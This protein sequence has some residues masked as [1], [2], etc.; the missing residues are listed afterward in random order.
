MWRGRIAATA[1]VAAI[2]AACT[3][4]GYDIS[5]LAPQAS[6]RTSA[7]VGGPRYAD[8]DPH[9]WAGRTPWT[10]AIHGTDVAKYQN[11]V[12]WR[13]LRRNGISFAFIK[14]T[15]GGDLVDER[16]AQNWRGAKAAGIPRGAYHFYYFCR[17][18]QEQAAWFIRNVPR[19]AAAL[20]PVLDMEWNPASPTCRLRPPPATVRAE[21]RTFLNIV[22]RH[23]GKKP[24]IY[25]SIDFYEDNGLA[26]FHGYPWWLRSVAAHPIERYG[27]RS[28]LFWQYTGTGVLPGV[29]G[30]VDINVFHGSAGEWREWLRNNTR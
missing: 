3:S 8:N 24:I 18:A 23:Y 19:E 2:A 4:S 22:E 26:S 5:D 29:E 10:Y 1:I 21:M 11:E 13:A 25:T 14:A 15:E 16:F 30:D 20:P 6:G 28:F 12:D 27:G 9:E 7:P 17:T